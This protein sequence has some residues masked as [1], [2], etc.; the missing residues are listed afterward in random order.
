MA[1]LLAVKPFT[2]GES[3]SV[4]TERKW[5]TQFVAE[6]RN[7]FSHDEPDGTGN[8]VKKFR[9]FSESQVRHYTDANKPVGAWMPV[10][11]YSYRWVTTSRQHGTLREQR[12]P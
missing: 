12:Q 4:R 10:C 6:V 9:G 2:E 7:C 1:N 5:L 8:A 3:F 11:V